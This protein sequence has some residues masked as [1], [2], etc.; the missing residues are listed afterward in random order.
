MKAINFASSHWP[1]QPTDLMKKPKMKYR[2][3]FNQFHRFAFWVLFCWVV[4]LASAH[5]D[6][7][8]KNTL[9]TQVLRFGVLP[10]SSP[11]I[12]EY[13]F[14]PLLR[15]LEHETGLHI[16][17]IIPNNYSELIHQ[18]QAK[19]IDMALFGGYTFVMVQRETNAEPLVVRDTDLHFSTVFITQPDNSK[20]NIEDFKGTRFSFGAKLS[21]S[22]HIMPR[23]FLHE[24]NINSEKFFSEVR[25]SNG[26]DT[27]MYWVRNGQVDLG[28][29]NSDILRNLIKDGQLGEN[30]VRILWETP[31]YT[32]YVFTLQPDFNEKLRAQLLDSFLALTPRVPAH[33]EILSALGASSFL[34]A[35]NEDFEILRK[36]VKII[37]L[38]DRL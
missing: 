8:Q 11:E 13:R 33:Q 15:Y 19:K 9:A 27:T 21:T 6:T 12:I 32:N 22:G 31:A 34:P 16:E 14:N 4:V 7:A 38:Q 2:L 35:N 18:F 3:P 20:Q 25:Y 28:A 29:V 24:R 10:N 26:H 17:M 5:A 30:D 23:Y 1:D 37:A 36:I